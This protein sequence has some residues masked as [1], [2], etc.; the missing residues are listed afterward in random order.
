VSLIGCSTRQIVKTEY[1]R[2]QVAGL[3]K[4][5]EYYPVQWQHPPVSPLTKG[6]I[7]GGGYCLDEDNAKNLL[8]NRE[9]DK[10]YQEEMRRILEGMK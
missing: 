9:L 3:P 10:G 7:E 5:P 2:Q 6:G 4:E 8:K 1:I